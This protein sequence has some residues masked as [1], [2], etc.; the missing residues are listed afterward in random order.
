M[1]VERELVHCPKLLRLE[2]LSGNAGAVKWLLALWGYCQKQKAWR[3]K[4]MTAERLADACLALIEPDKLMEFL[5]KTRWIEMDQKTLVVRKWDYYNGRLIQAWEANAKSI[6]SRSSERSSE[7]SSGDKA[8]APANAPT[9]VRA[10][11]RWID[12]K[13]A[14][15]AGKTAPGGPFAGN[16]EKSQNEKEIER[17]LVRHYSGDTLSET[18]KDRLYE[19]KLDAQ[20]TGR[21]IFSKSDL[22]AQILADKLNPDSDHSNPRINPHP[23]LQIIPDPSENSA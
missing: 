15:G 16:T 22:A 7:R 9:H 19:N 1:R 5:I 14:R 17:L 23:K 11:D 18:E 2:A 13:D 20:K 21:H 12:R 4:D 3:F 6:K 8:N 10:I